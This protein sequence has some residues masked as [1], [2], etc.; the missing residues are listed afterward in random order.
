M[1]LF[2]EFQGHIIKIY[3][4]ILVIHKV[5][6]SHHIL[7]NQHLLIIG[8]VIHSSKCF[9]FRGEKDPLYFNSIMY[10]LFI[11]IIIVGR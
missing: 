7:F 6:A 8:K 5:E 9:I 4:K 11:T 2:N 10:M 1:H 3:F